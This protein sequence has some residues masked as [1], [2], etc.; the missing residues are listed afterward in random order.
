[1][2]SVST[3]RLL[4]LWRLDWEYSFPP[5]VRVDKTAFAYLSAFLAR[6]RPYASD[7]ITPG[8]RPTW[9]RD[10]FNDLMRELS[11]RGYGG[12]SPREVNKALKKMAR[13]KR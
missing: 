11:C 1:L 12:V 5:Q 13:R 7:G 6:N 10:D 8:G 4:K 2:V 3:D 9:T